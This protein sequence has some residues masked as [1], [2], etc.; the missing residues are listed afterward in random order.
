MAKRKRKKGFAMHTIREIFR[1]SLEGHIQNR[2]IARSLGVSH[3]AVNQYV[4][5]AKERGL[6]F[7]QIEKLSDAE[8]KRRLKVTQSTDVS[9]KRPQADWAVIHQELKRKGVTLQLLW[10]EYKAVHPEGYQLSQFYEHYKQWKKKLAVSLRQ[11]HKAG[12]K[13]FVDYAGHTIPVIDRAT[14]AVRDAQIFVS[15]LGASNY[16]YA[17]ASFSQGLYDWINAHVHAFEFFGGCPKIVVCDNLKSGV[18]QTCRYEPELNRTYQEMGRHYGIAI[19]PA[20]VRKPKDKSKVEVGVQVV[21]R[22]ILAAL[23]NRSFFRLEALNDAIF[24]LLTRLNQ[25]PFK[26]LAGSRASCFEALEKSVL[27]PLPATRYTVA[28]WKKAR[29]NIDDH[30]ELTGHYY[31]VPY[32]LVREE[33]EVRFTASCVEVFSQGNRVASHRRRDTKGGHTPVSKHMP[34]S[35]RQYL[36]WSPSRII[37]WAATIGAS[38]AFVVER[39][40]SSRSHPEQGYRS[41]LGILRLCKPYSKARLE[42]ACKRAMT[43]GTGACRYKSIRSILETGLDRQPLPERQAEK[44]IKHPNIRGGAYY[45]TRQTLKETPSC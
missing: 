42:A 35:H 3:T 29:V 45:E 19:I 32:L 26:K 22:W 15:V 24:E 37:A 28:E 13:L 36:E 20:R 41:C 5:F 16:T 31:S 2:D 7:D 40:M 23:R 30:M 39:I 25:R 11:S 10:Q 21:E 44:T 8:L 18:T 38:T 12:E 1:L 9:V 4:R 33:V 34:K 17:E 27:N 14:G 43:I 6:N